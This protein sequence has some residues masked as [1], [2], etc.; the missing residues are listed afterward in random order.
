MAPLSLGVTAMDWPPAAVVERVRRYEAMGIP[1]AWLTTGRAGPDALTLFAACAVAT[2]R[3]HLGTAITPTFPRHPVVTVQQVEVVAHLARGRFR[4]GLGPSHRPIMEGLFGLPFRRPLA[5]LKE[6]LFVVRTL[7]REGTVRFEGEFFRVEASL[8]GP[9]PEVPVLI[10]ALRRPAFELAGEMADGAIT[11]LC[12]PDHLQRTALPG[13]EAGARRAGRPTP[14]LVAHLPVCVHPEAE[15][16]RSAVQRALGHYLHL[17]FY[18]RML[19]E[20]GFP[21]AEEG[22]WSPR[23]VDAVVAWGTEAQVADRVKALLAL[24]VAE[25]LAM[26][27]PA[28][29]DPGAS[30]ERTLRLLADL[31]CA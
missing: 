27:L 29:P 15:E 19:A 21:E 24:G 20:A 5:H 11:W 12:P 7:L 28:G 26:P 2:E 13:L 30:E 1:T 14:P 4:L 17:P 31:A 3:I 9:V 6:Y 16:V 23:M 18:R 22:R 25:V 10:S 8:P